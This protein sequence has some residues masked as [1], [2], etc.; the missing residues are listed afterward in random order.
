M[1][2]R[3]EVKRKKT[4]TSK[5]GKRLYVAELLEMDADL[6]GVAGNELGVG[7]VGKI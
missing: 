5:K 1:D 2:K 6:K 4:G 7:E 3:G